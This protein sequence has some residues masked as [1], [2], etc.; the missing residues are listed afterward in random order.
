MQEIKLALV[1][2]P[3]QTALAVVH[4][5]GIYE[6]LSAVPTILEVDPSAV[7]LFDHVGITLCRDV[8]QYARL[9]ENLHRR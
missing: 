3:Q 1:P 2:V 4:F 9:L 8:L 7:E 6:A 5:D